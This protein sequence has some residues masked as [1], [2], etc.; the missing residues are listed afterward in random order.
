MEP[1]NFEK[2]FR[3][4]LNQ[5]KIEPSDKAWDRLD[6]MLSIAEQKKPKKNAKW[7]LVAA[8]IV[9]FL[10]VTTVFVGKKERFIENQRDNV[11]IEYEIQKD[12]VI[13]KDSIEKDNLPLVNSIHN[14]IVI[15]EKN[16]NQKTEKSITAKHSEQISTKTKK[17][18]ASTIAES[19]VIN[20]KN[21]QTQSDNIQISI[22]E[23]VKNET[24]D[25]S[26]NPAVKSV[27]A[28]NQVRLKSKKIK[29]NAGDLLNQVDGELELSFREKV[30]T[31]V[32]KNY[33]T[34]K[35]AL[36]NRNQEE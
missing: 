19:S 7:I 35:V 12:S 1:N 16:S 11:A 9:G 6:A 13:R 24:T 33:Q 29:I 15:A 31:K 25:Q 34:V 21:Q 26:L 17:N 14:E 20:Q 22:P 30:I 5:R 4:K 28:E 18:T 10:L 8:G 3:E 2:D 23:T 36:A 32:N 27:V